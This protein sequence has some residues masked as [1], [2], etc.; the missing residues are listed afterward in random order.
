MKLFVRTFGCQMNVHDSERI[1]EIMVRAG[2]ELA[3]SPAEADVLVVNSCTV[4][5]KAWHKAISEAGRLGIQKRRRKE[6]LVVVA[7]CVAEQEKERVWKLVPV[8][9]LVVGP[10]RYKE[11]P[12]MVEEVR[13]EGGRAARHGFDAGQPGDFLSTHA[14]GKRRAASAFL[15]V[16]K[17]CSEQCSYCIV[18]SVRG[19]RRSRP[20]VDILGEAALLV[21]EGARELTLLGQTV[22]SYRDGE[23]TFGRLLR[24]MDQLTLLQ[25]LRFTS[26]HPRFMTQEVID[27]FGALRTLCESLHLPVQSGS[28]AVLARM[29]RRYTAEHYRQVAQ[30]LRRGCE[31][32]SLTTD[33]IVGYPGETDADFHETLRLI[34]EV[35]FAGAFSFKYSTRP[36]TPAAALED[37]VPEQVKA[38]RLAKVHEV[39]ERL[40]ASARALEIGRT[41]EVLVEGKGRNAGQV[42]GRTRKNQIVNFVPKQRTVEELIGQLV[43][44]KVRQAL[45]HSL[46]GEEA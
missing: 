2:Y 39:I 18:P 35:G 8:V 14:S 5:E 24:E 27:C 6:V 21:S 20:S 38:E 9:D 11:L 25:R 34:E 15:T 17:G 40:S 3:L 31:D 1:E 29:K 19:P 45:P 13:R 30:G 32:I 12:A 26:P 46:E 23:L 28:D 36:G 41:V 10:D 16:M 22:N 7:G 44:A 43:W 33:I 42:T 37:D 4:R